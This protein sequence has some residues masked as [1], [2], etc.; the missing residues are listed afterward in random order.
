MGYHGAPPWVYKQ[1]IAREQAAH[2]SDSYRLNGRI[3]ELEQENEALK[4]RIKE[5]EAENAKLKKCP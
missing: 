1:Q 3:T 2:D 4:K 5:L